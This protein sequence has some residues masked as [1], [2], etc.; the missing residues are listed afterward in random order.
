MLRLERKKRVITWHASTALRIFSKACSTDP[1]PECK[2]AAGRGGLTDK[3]AITP[4]GQIMSGLPVP[5]Q[6]CVSLIW[7][8]LLGVLDDVLISAAGV[9]GRDPFSVRRGRQCET[10]FLGC[11]ISVSIVF[12][13]SQGIIRTFRQCFGWF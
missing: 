6:I 1:D 3:E 11:F 12:R 4:L 8:I 7:G 9:T 2:R 13:R 5:P 10:V